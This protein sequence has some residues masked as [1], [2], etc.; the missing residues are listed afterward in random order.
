M[1][2]TVLHR[3]S[4]EFASAAHDALRSGRPDDARTLFAQAAR[5]EE[6]AL[7]QL[8][9]VEKPRTY[10]ITAVSAVA[11]WYKAQELAQAEQLAYT[12]LGSSGIPSFAADQLRELLQTVWNETTQKSAAVNF[13]PGQVMVSVQGG[14]VVRGGAPLDLVVD[15]VQTIQ[16]LFYRT[17]EFLQQLPLRR[18]GSA[19]REIQELCRPWL[20]QSVPSSYQFAVAIQGPRQGDLFEEPKPDPSLVAS[21]FLSILESAAGD[22]IDALPRV[23]PDKEY[24]TTFLKLARNLAPSGRV[25]TRMEIRASQDRTPI[26]LT[27][28][29][30]K[31]LS[32]TIRSET[33]REPVPPT[34]TQQVLHGTLR[35]VHLDKDW[36]ELLVDG[37]TVHVSGVGETV[38][39]VI[40][41]MV[42]HQVTVHATRDQRGIYRFQDIE[43]EE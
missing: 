16:A 20:F 5:A 9:L 1:T 30:R 19:P 13:I 35:G 21:T 10:G 29:S 26:L 33:P 36:L 34:S 18:R 11:L 17:A 40:G 14:E 31:A 25:F 8:D 23:V 7:E 27:A 6:Q 24:R 15:K 41:P 3:S 32:Q 4:E 12:I 42:N 28:D 38:D 39:D 37:Q 22:P 2:W 43:L